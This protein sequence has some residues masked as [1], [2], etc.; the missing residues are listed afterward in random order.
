M[1]KK[2]HQMMLYS[3]NLTVY[4]RF[5]FCYVVS[6]V[7]YRPP[8]NA[9]EANIFSRVCLSV[10]Y[11]V[12]RGNRGRPRPQSPLCWT[13]ALAPSVQVPTTPFLLDVIKFE[14]G[15]QCTGVLAAPSPAACSNLFTMKH[16]LSEWHSTEM[17]SCVECINIWGH[18]RSW[19][20][21][22]ITFG[23]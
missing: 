13:P 9:N 12:H 4:S 10:R 22:T 2:T 20:L 19:K 6:A 3:F 21:K 18:F 23:I 1:A 8:T 14:L 15:P 11:S 17:P 7:S 16:R 5:R